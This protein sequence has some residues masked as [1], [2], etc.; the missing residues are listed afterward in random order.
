MAA[1]RMAACS[2]VMASRYSVSSAD[3]TRGADRRACVASAACTRSNSPVWPYRAN[4]A[5]RSRRMLLSPA[6]TPRST[7]ARVTVGIAASTSRGVS[8][9]IS[10]STPTARAGSTRPWVASG[11]TMPRG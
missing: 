3:S 11:H 7:R 5:G 8:R 6:S 10:S 4:N 1:S 9:S 2:G